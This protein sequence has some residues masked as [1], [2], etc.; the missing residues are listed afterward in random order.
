[1]NYFLSWCRPLL[2]AFLFHAMTSLLPPNGCSIFV[3]PSGCNQPT[4]KLAQS[5]GNIHRVSPWSVIITVVNSP[6]RDS[7]APR[8]CILVVLIG[9][10]DFYFDVC[11]CIC[12]IS[13]FL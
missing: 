10:A 3:T 1:M 5:T 11:E 4:R 6:E 13:M 2:V 12:S 7:V 8:V 9:E